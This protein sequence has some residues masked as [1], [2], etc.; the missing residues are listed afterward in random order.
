MTGKK[1]LI[2]D[3]EQDI[4][5][6]LKFV[7][8]TE[9]LNCITA[10]DGEEALFKAKNEK[11]DLI[12]LDVMLPKINGYK[13]C[14]LL[15]FDAK[16]KDIPILMVTARSQEE[17]KSIGEETGADEYITKPFDIDEVVNIAKQYLNKGL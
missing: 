3:D 16:Y 9:G 13:V 15:K 7:L 11:P 17:D 12:I 1:I 6:T 14:R 10:Y 5:E 4:V 2:V 8:E